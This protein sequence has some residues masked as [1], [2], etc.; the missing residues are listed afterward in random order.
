M[1]PLA[2]ALRAVI[3]RVSFVMNSQ[4]NKSGPDESGWMFV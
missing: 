3:A 1:M 2:L 4:A